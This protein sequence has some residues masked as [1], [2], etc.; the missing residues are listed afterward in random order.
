M[1]KN[2]LILSSGE[3]T[4]NIVNKFNVG[5]RNKMLK[6]IYNKKIITY[7]TIKSCTVLF[8]LHFVERNCVPIF[9]HKINTDP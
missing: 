8:Q 2:M 3:K 6:F 4:A 5:L 7:V 1:F 9:K